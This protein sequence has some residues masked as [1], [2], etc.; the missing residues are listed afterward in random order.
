MKLQTYSEDYILSLTSVRDNEVKLGERVLT[1]SSIN[2][3][4]EDLVNSPARFVL[5][6]LPEDIGV[7]ANFGRT[8]ARS[9]WT[10]ALKSFLNVQSND[11]LS[12]SETLVLGHIDFAD[13]LEQAEKLNPLFEE[14][15]TQLRNL[16][17]EVDKRVIKIVK[18]IV[19]AGKL[20]I[21]IGGGHNNSYPIIKA[22]AEGLHEGGSSAEKA[23]NC[24]NLDPHSDFR[25]LEGRHSG[26]GFSYA[27]NEGVLKRYFILGIHQNYQPQEVLSVLKTHPD[28]GYI[29][30]ESI[31][32]LDKTDFGSAVMDGINFVKDRPAGIEIDMDALT[33]MP[34]SAE[35]PSGF[36]VNN[37]RQYIHRA[38]CLLDPAYLHIAEGAPSLS[39]NPE[40]NRVAKT[41]AYLITDFMK[42]I[43]PPAK[44][45]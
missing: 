27:H 37:A 31:T 33:M 8:G 23:I 6:G 20:P 4:F 3:F 7:K 34:S 21:I 44:S 41:I 28:L 38:G 19:K 42:A 14:Q 16:V 2:T 25:P 26:N 17:E 30:F 9:A 24:I 45:K 1:V 22:V 40:D 32:L 12:G 11:Y 15:A 29:T 10:Q 18:L 13:L 5:L 43:R 36:L 39:G 35:T